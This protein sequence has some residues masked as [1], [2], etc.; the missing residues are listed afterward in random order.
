[1]GETFGSRLLRATDRKARAG[2]GGEAYPWV[3]DTEQLSDIS[4]HLDQERTYGT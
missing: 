3:P 2:E 1:M 4:P